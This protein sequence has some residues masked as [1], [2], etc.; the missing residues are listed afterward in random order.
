MYDGTLFNTGNYL[1]KSFFVNTAQEF[2]L[3]ESSVTAAFPIIGVCCETGV[4]KGII[5]E[6]ERLE[7]KW[8]LRFGHQMR[9]KPRMMLFTRAILRDTHSSSMLIKNNA[10]SHQEPTVS[11]INNII[12]LLILAKNIWHSFKLIFIKIILYDYIYALINLPIVIVGWQWT[13]T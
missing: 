5:W 7:T 2:H 9:L 11:K 13:N 8:L 3:S 10:F 12:I 4:A 1:K 6:G